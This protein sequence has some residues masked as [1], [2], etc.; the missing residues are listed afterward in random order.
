MQFC[1]KEFEGFPKDIG[2]GEE[3]AVQMCMSEFINL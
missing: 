3:R 2:T 1:M